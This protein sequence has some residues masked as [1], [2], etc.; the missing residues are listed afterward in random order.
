ML[1]LSKSTIHVH[2]VKFGYT[3]RFDIWAPHFN[4]E[5][6]LCFAFYLRLALQTKRRDAIFEA[7]SNG[8]MLS[9]KNIKESRM[10]Q[11]ANPFF[12]IRRSC[13]AFGVIVK[14]SNLMSDSANNIKV[15]LSFIPI[16]DN[17]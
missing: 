4:Q 3:N 12:I 13:S 11:L 6:F 17:N 5:N 8:I 9:E 14:E 16:H 1:K 15:L 10:N 2:F 7:S